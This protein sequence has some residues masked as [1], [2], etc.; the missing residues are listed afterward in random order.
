MTTILPAERGPWDVISKSL[1]QSLE[2]SLPQVIQRRQGLD[3]LSRAEAEIAQAGNDPYKIAMAFARAG[4]VNPSLERSLGPLMQ[5]AMQ[6]GKVNRAFPSG[7]TPAPT[8]SEGTIQP[9]QLNNEISPTP[10]NIPQ[11]YIGAPL[12]NISSFATPT[13][14]NIMTPQDIDA[15]SQRYAQAVNDPN[16]YQFR[17]AQ[18]QNQNN[19][20]QEQLAALQNLAANSDV[21]P[22]EMPRFMQ[23]GAKFDPRNPT[24]WLQNT[25]RA[26]KAVK[27][28][29]DKI[30]RAFIPGIGSALLGRD[31]EAAL[32]RLEKPVQ[33]NV[34]LGL[35]QETRDYLADQYLSSTEIEELIHP[36]QPQTKKAISKMP[37][38]F[39]KND[40][41][42]SKVGLYPAINNK[43]RVMSYEEALEKNP[44]L[45]MKDQNEL[46]NFFLENVTPESSLLTMREPLWKDK[47]YDWRQ[48]GPAIREAEKRGLKL[49][50]HQSTEMADIETQPPLQSLPD[51]F[52]DLD[53]IPSYLRG[54]K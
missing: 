26:Y 32:K 18:L 12:P 49:Q 38:S 40:Q 51:I 50:Q 46:A 34:K 14:F 9:D 11:P 48:F 52:M 24:E 16:Q 39:L 54:N 3:A 23:V 36:L 33:D 7:Q 10:N 43:N 37:D 31:R 45:L 13:P 1:G 30:Q 25:K 4:A 5:T 27:S 2:N 20:A 53:R 29:D 42:I 35:E 6:G 21:R 28:N 41:S 19:A 15:E 17:Q 22:D 47:G 8:T 44:D